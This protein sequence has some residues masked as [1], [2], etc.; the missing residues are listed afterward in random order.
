MENFPAA[1][2]RESEQRAVSFLA[3]AFARGQVDRNAT[4]ASVAHAF[5]GKT[6]TPI[7]ARPVARLG[8]SFS[9]G[10]TRPFRWTEPGGI[11]ARRLGHSKQFPFGGREINAPPETP[12]AKARHRH[13]QLISSSRG[14][15]P[16]PVS[17]AR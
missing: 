6:F 8:V 9:P 14:G 3:P 5:P 10:Q 15:S 16:G 4:G 12:Q 7:R 1:A 11:A 2:F 17:G 13:G